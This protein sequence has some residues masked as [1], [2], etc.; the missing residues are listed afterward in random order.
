MRSKKRQ[1]KKTIK[2]TPK[3]TVL[4]DQWEK[5]KIFV[6]K[7]T[8]NIFYSF[9]SYIKRVVPILL[10]KTIEGILIIWNTISL[11][12]QTALGFVYS[13]YIGLRE[14]DRIWTYRVEKEARDHIIARDIF[15]HSRQII[16]YLILVA[17]LS[18]LLDW[19]FWLVFSHIQFSDRL[20]EIFALPSRNQTEV[21]LEIFVGAISAILG[22]IFALY[23]VGVQLASDRYSEKVSSFII[24]EPVTDYFFKFLIFTDLFSLLIL[25]RLHFASNL[26]IISFLLAAVL[27]S[28]SIMGILVFRSHYVNS[29]KPLSLFERLWRVCLDQFQVVTNPNNYKYKS[30]SLTIHCRDTTNRHLNIFADLFRDLVRNNNWVDA[31]YGP[32]VLSHILRDYLEIKKL[33]DKEKGWWFFEKYEQVKADDLN[34][35]TVKANYE[36]QGKGPLHIP[37][38]S[39]NW[40]EDKAIGFLEEMSLHIHED[41]SNKLVGRIADGY[42]ELLVGHYEERRGQKPRL[43]PGAIQNQEFESFQKGIESFLPLWQKIDFSNADAGVVFLNDYFAISEELLEKWDVDKTLKIAESFYNGD[44]LNI[45]KK[46]LSKRDL[47]SYTRDQLLSYWERLEVEQRLEGKIITP[48]DR[49]AEEIKDV[50]VDKRREIVKNYLTRFFDNSDQI[51]IKLY[52]DKNFEYVGHFIKMQYEWVSRLLY[53]RDIELAQSFAQRIKKN[54]AFVAYLPKQ[55]VV[56]LELL[57]QIE[58]GFFVSLVER[59]KSLFEVYAQTAVLILMIIRTDET[60]QDKLFRLMKLPVIW[61]GV[62]YLVSELDSDFHY[63][64][65]F[66]EALEGSFRPGWMIEILE[67]VTEL[68]P[69]RNIWWETTRYHSWYMN[70]LNRLRDELRVIPYQESGALGFSKRYDHPSPFIQELA[71]W[72]MMDEERCMEGFID[73]LKLREGDKKREEIKKLT[74]VLKNLVTK[75]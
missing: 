50:L 6:S 44:Q 57:E 40:L 59:S 68:R 58:K 23:A 26:P 74:T 43:E 42:K 67:K 69:V 36:L 14:S 11:R 45:D 20:I 13:K 25:L 60:D 56:D 75:K 71:E 12:G 51:I 10:N 55:S 47:P 19:I 16:I 38:A 53:L 72:E 17:S 54:A 37:K 66:S 64:T 39:E 41:K 62:A 70:L 5:V 46:F 18:F 34:M 4:V 30:W 52:K 24:Q 1:H 29:M 8:K 49:F 27:V 22:L 61:G 28:L 9:W 48:K 65:C 3:K 2:T 7:T 32:I 35:F 15:R 73:W 31:S 21:G 63:V 33:V